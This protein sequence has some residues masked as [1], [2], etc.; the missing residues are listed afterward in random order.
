MNKQDNT[1]ESLVAGGFIGAAL[2]AWL[3]KDKEEGA[4]IGA[5]LCAVFAATEHANREAIKTNQAVLQVEKGSLYRI[6]PNGE[7]QFVK[8]LRR[9]RKKWDNHFKLK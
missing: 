5:L 7:K 2:G 4:L 8:S 1:L 6:L 3:S 9:T